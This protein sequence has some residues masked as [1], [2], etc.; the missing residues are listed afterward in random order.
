MKYD[1]MV[2]RAK[3]VKAPIL[4]GKGE[5]SMRSEASDAMTTMLKRVDSRTRFSIRIL[6]GVIVFLT[7]IAFAC[8]IVFENNL[9]QAGFGL[10]AAAFAL[11]VFVQQ[12]RYRVYNEV[13]E[14]APM[15]EYLYRAKKRMR[16]FTVRTWLALPV[17]ILI[18]A[19]ICLFIFSAADHFDFPA[20]YVVLALQVLLVFVVALDFWV[21]YLI[22]KKE[23]EPA[24]IEINRMLEEIEAGR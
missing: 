5:N 2:N 3:K 14:G 17:W 10:I 7:A 20:M 18:D 22:W 23:H 19:G 11:I 24:V 12:L 1:D 4:G 9:V 15:L 21:D 8:V 13:Y 16:V 6:Q